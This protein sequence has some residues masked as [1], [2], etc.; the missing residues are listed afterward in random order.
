MPQKRVTIQALAEACQLSR[1]TVSKV[2]NE[3]GRVPESTRQFVLAKA[4][5]LGYYSR[6]QLSA[7]TV[8]AGPGGTIAVLSWS[9]PLNH[10]F[11]SMLMKAFTD[12]VCRWGY[13]VQMYELSAAE[14]AEHRLPA[15]VSAENVRGVLCIELFDRNYYEMLSDLK[16]PTVSVDAYCQVNRSPILCDV[17]T[18]ENMRSVIALTRQL[19]AA[20]ARSLSFVGDRFHCNSFCERWNGFY[21]ALRDA[22]LEP[23]LRLCIMEKDGS[24]YAD[25]DWTLARLKEMPRLPDAFLCAN[26]FHAVKLIQALKKHGC[27]IP[28]DVM[29]AGFDDG[30]EAAVIEPSLTTVHIPSSEMGIHAAELLLGRIRNPDRPYTMTYV[31][32]TPVFRDSTRR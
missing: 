5:E 31:Q 20:G 15:G 2:F 22:G 19:L 7:P 14:L 4:R 23:D 21:T 1:N 9:N 6:A 13:S 16:L 27:R 28:E 26:D 11:G 12:T 17:I 3:R 25:P 30:P 18:M 24:Q 10:N 8:P 32:T 29:V